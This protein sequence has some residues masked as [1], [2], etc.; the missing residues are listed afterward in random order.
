MNNSSLI[1]CFVKFFLRNRIHS[2]LY[3][4][5]HHNK[6]KKFYKESFHFI[7][8]TSLFCLRII[9][10]SKNLLFKPLSKKYNFVSITTNESFSVWIKLGNPI[11]IIIFANSNFTINKSYSNNSLQVT[12][13]KCNLSHLILS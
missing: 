8:Y 5:C 2:E 13:L 7:K 3:I 11:A 10:L 1:F 12:E 4:L 9:Y 6:N